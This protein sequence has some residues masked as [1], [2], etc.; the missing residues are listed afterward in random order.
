M[1]F[2]RFFFS[3]THLLT[4]PLSSLL[5]WA[6][7]RKIVHPSCPPGFLFFCFEYFMPEKNQTLF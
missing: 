2:G 4:L 5:S 7:M 3:Q 6:T 1:H